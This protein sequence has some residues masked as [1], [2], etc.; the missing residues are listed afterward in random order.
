MKNKNPFKKILFCFYTYIFNIGEHFSLLW[1]GRVE[2]LKNKIDG[3]ILN[4]DEM[5]SNWKDKHV[6]KVPSL[7]NIELTA[8]Y[9]H[10]GSADTRQ[11]AVDVMAQYPLGRGLKDQERAA[12]IEFL[13]SLTGEYKGRKLNAK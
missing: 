12:I 13:K 5:A 10:D 8:P 2:T 6:F 3:P 7:R 4:P 1:D 9:F 11:D